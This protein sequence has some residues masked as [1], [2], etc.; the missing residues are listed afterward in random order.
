MVG[1]VRAPLLRELILNLRAVTLSVASLNRTIQREDHLSLLRRIE[2]DEP[3]VALAWRPTCHS[4]QLRHTR[5]LIRS[6]DQK[7]D[8]GFGSLAGRSGGRAV[9]PGA[10]RISV[11]HT[12]VP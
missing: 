12:R 9:A 11:P 5:H 2:D 6:R 10:V 3:A 4:N 1:D 7:K 8:S